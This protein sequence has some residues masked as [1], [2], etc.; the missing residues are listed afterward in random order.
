MLLP[1][2]AEDDRKVKGILSDS[3]LTVAA[4]WCFIGSGGGAKKTGGASD[5]F[6]GFDCSLSDRRMSD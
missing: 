5:F 3:S 1:N 4:S 2:V 6:N